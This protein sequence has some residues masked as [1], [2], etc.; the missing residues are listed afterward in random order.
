MT[1][2]VK[3]KRDNNIY[4]IEEPGI[5]LHP[6]GQKDLVRLFEILSKKFQIVGTEEADV[7]AGRIS[8]A[9]PIA[10]ALI[11]KK[12]GDD[13]TINVPKGQIEYEVVSIKY[14]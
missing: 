10:K 5:H 9:S 3:E 8:I 1:Q 11:N 12:V 2:S 6:S 7:K 13:V 4:L 14:E